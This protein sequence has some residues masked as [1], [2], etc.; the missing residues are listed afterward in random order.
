MVFNCNT[1]TYIFISA[2][3]YIYIYVYVCNFIV[4]QLYISCMIVGARDEA[5]PIFVYMLWHECGRRRGLEKMQWHD[6][7]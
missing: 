7:I 3:I 6:M 2:C 1:N 4:I 5:A